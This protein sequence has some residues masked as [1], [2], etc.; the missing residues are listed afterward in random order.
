MNRFLHVT[1]LERHREALVAAYDP[2][3][4]RITVCG[5]TGCNAQGSIK[6]VAALREAVVAHGLAGTVDVKVTGCHGFCEKGPVVVVR[7]ANTFYVQV[8]AE[9]ADELVRVTLKE[10]GVVDRLLYTDPTSGRTIVHEQEVPFYAQQTRIIL[11]EN[12]HLDPTSIDDYLVRGGYAALGKAIGSM[13]P[14]GVIAEVKKAG[15]RGRGGAGFPTGVKWE[16]CRKQDGDEKYVICNADEGDPGAYMNRS[17]IE[18]NPH[19]ILEGM[20]IGAY[21]IG[22]RHAYIYCRAEYPLAIEQLTR[23]IAQ[24][25]AYGLLGENILGSGFSLDFVIKQGAGAFVCGEET[26]LMHSIEGKRGMPTPRPPFPAQSGVFGKPS[27]INNVE[28]WAN[29]PLIINRGAGWF[30]GIGSEK[31]KG[32]KV[33]SLVGCVKNTG[34]VEVPFGTSLRTIIEDI[35]G[36]TPRGRTFKAAQMGGPSGGC[37]PAAHIDTPLDYESLQALGAIVGSGGL[38]VMDDT[39]C[40]VDLARY[41][42]E[43]IQ[44]ESCGKCI[45]CREGTRRMKEILDALTRSRR[46]EHD[47]DPLIRMQGLMQLKQLAETIRTTALCGLGQTAPNP[48]LSTLRY[49]RDEYEAHLYDRTCPAGSCKELVGT[50]C[51]NACPV[52]TEVWRYVAHVGRGEY[53]DAYRVI[54]EANPFPSACARVCH[55]PCERSCRAGASGTGDPVAIRTLKRFVVDNVPASTYRPIARRP[56]PKSARIAVVGAGPAGLTAANALSLLGHRVTVF[57]REAVPGGMLVGAIPAYR[58]PRERLS[59]EI[60]G[61]LN[62]NLEVRLEKALGRDFTV[63]SLLEEGYRAVYLALGSHRSKTLDLPGDE[64]DGILP[65]IRFL[66][67][68]NLHGENLA[69]GRVGVIG[70]G[71]SAMDAARVALRQPGVDGVTVY[72]RR[73]RDEMPAYADEIEAGLAEGITIE[74]LVAPVA[75]HTSAGKLTGVRLVRNRLSEPDASGRRRPEPMAGSEF[76]VEL[77]TLIVAISEGPETAT[78]EGLDLTKRGTLSANPESFLTSRPGVFAGGDVTTGPGTVIGAIAAGKRAALMIDRYVTGKL[79]RL[80]PKVKLPGV[81]IAPASDLEDEGS[82]HPASRV[83]TPHLPVEARASNFDEV[84]LCVSE[85]EACGE[86]HRCMR[87]DLEF[88]QPV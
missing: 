27:N 7:P 17:E 33:F 52:G 62:D 64:A 82:A 73:T 14:E 29:V 53:A 24:A 15:L 55:H 47:L 70:G 6:L 34:L 1:D 54:R 68:Y 76:D 67:A 63:D 31:S 75:L 4:T 23:G 37:I 59:A 3:R 41:F 80:L 78:L 44:S 85:V 57:E 84:E 13:T 26:A 19:L 9:D 25:K 79:L 60:E 8:K 74:P 71:N 66:K 87:C 5:G 22:A 48:V 61:L 36:G 51:Q 10:N 32:T 28:T 45:P 43:F 21:A 2:S 88:T 46:K 11:A 65:G 38:V 35:G 50:P 77:D 12:G 49:F 39:T 81:F 16:L 18:G 30:S 42:M 86:A 56:G 20:I 40:M 58:L 69:V 83:A 72:Y